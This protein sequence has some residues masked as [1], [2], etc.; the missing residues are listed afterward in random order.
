MLLTVQSHAFGDLQVGD[1]EPRSS[2]DLYLSHEC[3]RCSTSTTVRER[4]LADCKTNT[5]T[6]TQILDRRVIY[7][8][9][10]I[11]LCTYLLHL[12]LLSLIRIKVV[13]VLFV[14]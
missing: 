8:L 11:Y 10:V 5:L 4:C 1:I 9:K 3:S 6:E 14:C 12:K 13:R 2:C 7:Q